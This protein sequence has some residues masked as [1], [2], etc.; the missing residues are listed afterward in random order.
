VEPGSDVTVS[1]TINDATGGPAAGVLCAFTILNQPG[2][3]ASVETQLANTDANGNASTTLHVGSTEGTVDVQAHCGAVTLT[4]SV[5]VSIA[6][7]P[8][9][10]LPNSGQGPS[11]L[12]S[13][14]QLIEIALAF[15]LVLLGL[16]SA[17]TV[18]TMRR[19]R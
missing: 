15:F 6:A 14:D 1:V 5:E 2:T 4:T 8:P 13:H 11:G 18:R 9:A 10:S 17:R 19:A 3:D 12:T 7:G 16:A